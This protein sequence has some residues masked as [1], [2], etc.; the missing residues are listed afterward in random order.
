MVDRVSKQLTMLHP[1]TSI[2]VSSS[3]HFLRCFFSW[4]ISLSAPGAIFLIFRHFSGTISEAPVSG[5]WDSTPVSSRKFQATRVDEGNASD[6]RL[7]FGPV[8]ME[9]DDSDDEEVGRRALKEKAGAD[10]TCRGWS[11]CVGGVLSVGDDMISGFVPR[12]LVPTVQR[13]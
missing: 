5:T 10:G 3:D 7:C 12:N 6:T 11:R 9:E 1:V 2:C 4:E 13:R 8:A